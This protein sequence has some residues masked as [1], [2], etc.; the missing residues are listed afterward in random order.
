MN[1]LLSL[2]IDGVIGNH[3]QMFCNIYNEIKDQKK[4]TISSEQI[5]KIPVNKVE[6][7]CVDEKDERRIFSLPK[8]W[9]QMPL[10]D[11]AVQI[12]QKIHNTFGFEIYIFSCVT[13]AEK[14]MSFAVKSSTLGKLPK[15]G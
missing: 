11:K 7:L 9:T 5:K 1:I 6:G 13:G 14:L 12:M 2:D 8:Y 3:E 10:M 15:T 4:P